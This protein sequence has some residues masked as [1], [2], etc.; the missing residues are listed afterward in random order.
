MSSTATKKTT[1]S[2]PETA[3]V[4]FLQITHGRVVA[5]D[6]GDGKLRFGYMVFASGHQQS[7]VELDR[8]NEGE[9]DGSIRIISIP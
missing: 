9:K 2:R 1:K 4:V 5:P 8:A 3:T 7:N 6:E